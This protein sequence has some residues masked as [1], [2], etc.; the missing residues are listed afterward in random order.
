METMEEQM[1]FVREKG[2]T[3]LKITHYNYITCMTKLTKSLDE[4]KPVSLLVLATESR[5][6]Y[7]LEP[8]GLAIKK[9]L[10][11]LK[12]V[13]NI[14][15][16]VGQFE[17]DYRIYAGCR[18]GK[19]FVYRNGDLLLDLI[20]AIDSKPVGMV[21]FDKQ[22]IVAGMNQAITGFFIKGKK[23]YTMQMP[24]AVVDIIKVDVKRSA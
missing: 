3:D 7:I 8:N 17:V 12:S 16:T 2:G 22:I 24:S 21:V 5:N 15:E 10:P 18:D 11:Q 14:L 9:A 4:D 19:V 6:L 20:Y 1:H 13:A 23:N